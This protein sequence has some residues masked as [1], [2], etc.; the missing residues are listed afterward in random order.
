M[1]EGEHVAYIRCAC[2][3]VVQMREAEF[4]A[5]GPEPLR[6]MRCTAC[7]KRGQVDITWSW[8]LLDWPVRRG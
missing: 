2:G 1:A 5:L 3:R 8:R 6:R 7:G 4:F